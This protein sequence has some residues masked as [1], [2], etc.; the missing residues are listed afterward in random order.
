M[1]TE[2]YPQRR[3]QSQTAGQQK[4]QSLAHPHQAQTPEMPERLSPARPWATDL[5][6]GAR[7]GGEAEEWGTR[8]VERAGAVRRKS[9]RNPGSGGMCLVSH[10]LWLVARGPALP[11]APGL[12]RGWGGRAWRRRRDSVGRRRLRRR[13]I[14]KHIQEALVTGGSRLGGSGEAAGGVELAPGL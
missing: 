11:A 7:A 12:G 1:I 10:P 9:R 14:C 5:T 13:G 4:R 8:D 2:H 3:R 6:P